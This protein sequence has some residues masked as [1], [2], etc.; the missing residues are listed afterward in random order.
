M[1]R[2]SEAQTEH[3]KAEQYDALVREKLSGS[4]FAALVPNLTPASYA[5]V[6]RFN[7]WNGFMDFLQEQD[8]LV[9]LWT[10]VGAPN[11]A[12]RRVPATE[13]ALLKN[14]ATEQPTFITVTYRK[15]GSGIVVTNRVEFGLNA[16]KTALGANQSYLR[17]RQIQRRAHEVLSARNDEGQLTLQAQWESLSLAVLNGELPIMSFP[18]QPGPSNSL[19]VAFEY[20]LDAFGN[21]QRGDA[22]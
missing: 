12:P 16:A 1:R 6:Q 9:E 3:S 19:F 21:F 2:V 7:S 8:A 13:I 18:S 20:E 22:P 5:I 15:P 4:W 17:Q 10:Y 14:E 11:G